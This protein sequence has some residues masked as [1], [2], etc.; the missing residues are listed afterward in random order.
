MDASR[1]FRVHYFAITDK[2]T[3]T[4]RS[5]LSMGFYAFQHIFTYA[6]KNALWTRH[7]RPSVCS[8]HLPHSLRTS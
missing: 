6:N 1:H 2:T 8:Q 3:A 7:V 4:A 5:L